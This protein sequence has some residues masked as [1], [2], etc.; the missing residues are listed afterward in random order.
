MHLARVIA[1]LLLEQMVGHEK[2]LQL[3]KMK[4]IKIVREFKSIAEYN[5][6]K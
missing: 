6:V 2:T 1:D 5:S 3:S 4:E